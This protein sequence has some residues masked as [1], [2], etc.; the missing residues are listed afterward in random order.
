MQAHAG[1]G[2]FLRAVAASVSALGQF[3]VLNCH[4]YT[5]PTDLTL[6]QFLLSFELLSTNEATLA[7]LTSTL[8]MNEKGKLRNSQAM[9]QR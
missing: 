6:R 4:R 2:V 9:I 7:S 3:M 8:S 5:I 1:A